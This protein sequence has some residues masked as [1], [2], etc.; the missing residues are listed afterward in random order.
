MNSSPPTMKSSLEEVLQYRNDAVVYRFIETWELSFEDAQDL[1]RE[2][3]RWLWLSAYGTIHQT[4]VRE[5]AISQ[6]LKLLDEMWHTFILFTLDYQDFCERYFG[7]FLHHKPT[8]K[9]EYEAQIT[10]YER[11]PA[12]YL[13]QQKERFRAQY[14]LIYDVLGVET[15]VKWY[16]TYLERY[17]DLQMRRIWRWSFSPY[18]TRVRSQIRLDTP[19]PREPAEQ[20]GLSLVGS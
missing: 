14:A 11:D 15:L 7:F 5:L 16:S 10:T 17:T 2:T 8:S 1:F 13:A 18:D 6:S 3:L 9:E 12:Q 20:P 4:E 19:E